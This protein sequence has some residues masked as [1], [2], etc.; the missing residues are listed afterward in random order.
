MAGVL[1]LHVVVVPLY[2]KS[3]GPRLRI[4]VGVV[5]REGVSHGVLVHERK[6][7]DHPLVLG[8]SRPQQGRSFSHTVDYTELGGFDD[9]GVGFPASAWIAV[10]LGNRWLGL[11]LSVDRDDAGIVNHFT[12][13]LD[14]AWSLQNKG[15][16]VV[17]GGHHHTGRPL[18]DASVAL[19]HVLV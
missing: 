16:I 18:G 17:G 19:F 13:E 11:Q 10:S 15:A 2:R 1:E 4:G 6:P 7:F 14:V 9:Q 12:V 8:L 3:D 5:Q